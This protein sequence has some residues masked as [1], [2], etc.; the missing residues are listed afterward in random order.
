MRHKYSARALVLSRN[1]IGE[2]SV[3]VS[4]LTEDFGIIRA[5]SQGARKP[6]AKMAPAL[7]TLSLA[8]VTLIR[9]K[10]GWRTAGAI[11]E[12]N[13]AR[14]L[15][16]RARACAV[17]VTELAQRLVHGEHADPELFSILL[18]FVRSLE[19]LNEIEQEA[20]EMIAA[21]RVLH[22][23]GLDAG[24]TFG[25]SNDYSPERLAQ[26]TEVRTE[27]IAR[28]NHGIASSGLY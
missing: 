12:E 13:W 18:A 21:V 4:L 8:D 7:Q 17:R 20:A 23:L 28:I 11:L 5:R 3:S 15:T 27:L 1:Q 6:G 9:G 16:S 26:A 14:A 19:S 2:A 10:D 22:V 25:E 24:D